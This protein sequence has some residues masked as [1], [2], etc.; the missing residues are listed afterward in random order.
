MPLPPLRTLLLARPTLLVVC[1]AMFTGGCRQEPKDSSPLPSSQQIAAGD[2]LNLNGYKAAVLIFVTPECPISNRY[3][4]EIR[5]LHDEFVTNG[6]AFW[7]IYADPDVGNDRIDAHMREFRL[8]GRAARDTG[9]AL[10]R[11]AGARVTPE[12][13]VFGPGARLLYHGRIDDRY[14]SL[15]SDRAS[16]AH[17]ELRDVL[18][19]I[20]AGKP[21]TT[22]SSPAVGCRI[23]GIE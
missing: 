16:A 2:P 12:A 8:P 20:T 17:H 4:P 13:A 23:P 15:G 3:A 5:H 11:K 10:A 7:M 22:M 1:A 6:I 9:L 21:V 18:E 14:E 19:A